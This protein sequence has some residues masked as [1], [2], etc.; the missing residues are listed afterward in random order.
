MCRAFKR[1]LTNMDS[2]SDNRSSFIES[3]SDSMEEY[4]ADFEERNEM[5]M[6]RNLMYE[7]SIHTIK[8]INLKINTSRYRSP[9]PRNPAATRKPA[10]NALRQ[11]RSGSPKP[12]SRPVSPRAPVHKPPSKPKP[13]S[14]HGSPLAPRLEVSGKPAPKVRTR[15]VWK[16]GNKDSRKKTSGAA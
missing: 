2:E 8:R 12:L 13:L 1:L 10:G 9:P 4:S 3:F 5:D 7:K 16:K 6:L 11:A 14:R 15:R